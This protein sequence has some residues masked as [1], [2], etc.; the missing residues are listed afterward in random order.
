MIKLDFLKALGLL[1]VAAPLSTA[2]AGAKSSGSDAEPLVGLWEGVV[3]AGK[4]TYRYIWSIANGAYVVTGNVDEN[5]MGL[6]YSPSMGTYAR[7]ADRSYRYRERGYVF[8]LKGRNVGSFTSVGTFKLSSDGTTLTGP[9]TFTQF[10]LKSKE[11]ARESYSIT[12][13]RVTA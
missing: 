10:D 11:V 13:K 9:G 6:R 1:A 3:Q 7:S 12:A 5:Y 4:V 2:A 8:D